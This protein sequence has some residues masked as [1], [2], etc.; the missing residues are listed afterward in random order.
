[1]NNKCYQLRLYKEK[2]QTCLLLSNKTQIVRKWCGTFAQLIFD[3]II[4]QYKSINK[5]HNT[6]FLCKE[7][8][9]GVFTKITCLYQK[10]NYVYKIDSDLNK[11]HF[12]KKY[13]NI[14]ESLLLQI[15]INEQHPSYEDL[16]AHFLDEFSNYNYTKFDSTLTLL[17][18]N[19]IIQLITT[20]DSKQYF[21]KNPVPHKHIYF[22]KHKKLVDCT[23]EM[24]VFLN[25]LNMTTLASSTNNIYYVNNSLK[26]TQISKL[27]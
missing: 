10:L 21:D 23:N 5:N 20:E 22:R 16:L 14:A 7:Q 1:M 2:D 15:R 26:L 11:C 6:I 17:L 12:P 25:N 24:S 9:H 8:I 27:Y 4:V 13:L 18:K 19:R 3:K